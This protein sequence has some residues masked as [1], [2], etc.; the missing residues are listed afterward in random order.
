MKLRFVRKLY[1]DRD[2]MPRA[3]IEE[4]IMSGHPGR[5]WYLVTFSTSKDGMLDIYSVPDLK[6]PH[7]KDA[8]LE[9]VGV[10]RG[11][12]SAVHI[13]ERIVTDTIGKK[14][15]VDLHDYFDS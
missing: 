1:L 5:G 8:A 14:K 12:F 6:K 9:V 2:D 7:M 10:A 13:V 11:Y 3:T 15:G 4:R